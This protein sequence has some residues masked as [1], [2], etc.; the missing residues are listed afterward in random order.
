MLDFY[1]I[2]IKIEQEWLFKLDRHKDNRN[3][4]ANTKECKILFKY[5][6]I[7]IGLSYTNILKN[8][9]GFKERIILIFTQ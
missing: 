2:K 7:R 3:I 4:I 8:G 5:T 1:A 9:N 6:K